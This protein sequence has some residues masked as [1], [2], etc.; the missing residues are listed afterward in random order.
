VLLLLP[1]ALLLLPVIGSI[2]G[3]SSSVL[4]VLVAR[5][6]QTREEGPKQHLPLLQQQFVGVNVHRDCF[7]HCSCG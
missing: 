6:G 1:H 2:S 4:V 7:H 5:S 3:S